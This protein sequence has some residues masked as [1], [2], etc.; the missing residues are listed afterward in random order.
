MESVYNLQVVTQCAT[1]LLSD[2]LGNKLFI[3][4]EVEVNTEWRMTIILFE[5][6]IVF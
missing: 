4:Y 6:H 2:I 3:A 1:K 5:T